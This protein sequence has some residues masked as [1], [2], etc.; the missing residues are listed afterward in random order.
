M[1]AN[2]LNTLACLPPSPSPF[3]HKE[4]RRAKDSETVNGDESPSLLVGE[5]FR[6]GAS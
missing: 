2:E 5:G 1:T 6:V 4:G 3:P